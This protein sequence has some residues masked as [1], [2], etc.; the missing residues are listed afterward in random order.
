[1]YD[2]PLGSGA[3]RDP[4]EAGGAPAPAPALRSPGRRAR[5]GGAHG[6]GEEGADSPPYRYARAERDDDG[7]PAPAPARG[8]GVEAAVQRRRAQRRAEKRARGAEQAPPP[9]RTEWTRRVPHSVLI[10]HAASLTPY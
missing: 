8:A 6:A 4:R 1:V 9:L 2:A 3:F 7:A 10:G 5:H